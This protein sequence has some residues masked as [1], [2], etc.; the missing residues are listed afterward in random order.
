VT[1]SVLPV[2]AIAEVPGGAQDDLLAVLGAALEPV[3]IMAYCHREVAAEP[4]FL[5]AGRQWNE[6]NWQLLAD[7]EQRAAEV[8]VSEDARRAADATAFERIETVVSSQVDP[9]AYC[10]LVA[11]VI[12]AGYYD[13]DQ[14]DD[15]KPALRRI[16]G[17]D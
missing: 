14:R 3:G 17:N 12:E 7:L 11:N 15:L 9:V 4:A 10:R 6:R 8:P 2:V 16:F 1:F 5:A 13:I